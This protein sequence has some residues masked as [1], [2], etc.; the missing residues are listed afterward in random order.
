MTP[1][2]E[3]RICFL[4]NTGPEKMGY[5]VGTACILIQIKALRP[6]EM[7]GTSHPKT[8]GHIATNSNIPKTPL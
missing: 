5:S 7:S 1:V 2:M 6:S 8:Q 3:R 4:I